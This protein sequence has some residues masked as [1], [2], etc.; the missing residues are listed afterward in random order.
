VTPDELAALL[1]R[2]DPALGKVRARLLAAGGLGVVLEPDTSSFVCRLN[3][4]GRLFSGEGAAGNPGPPWTAPV[5]TNSAPG[6]SRS[7]RATP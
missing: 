6:C 5:S 7:S 3:A 2:C 4:A 1:I